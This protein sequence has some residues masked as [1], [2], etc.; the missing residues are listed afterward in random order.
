LTITLDM[1]FDEFKAN[2]KQAARDACQP[3]NFCAWDDSTE[4]CGCSVELQTSDPVL[5][6]ECLRAS[7]QSDSVCTWAG[8]D[9]D[10][11]AGG[12]YGIRFTMP[13]E[14]GELPDNKGGILQPD[15][16]RPDPRCF[17]ESSEWDVAWQEASEDL[18]GPECF[19]P[20]VQDPPDFCDSR[21]R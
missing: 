4:R 17:R 15:G 12:C 2:Y 19:Q 5:Y 1:G 6:Q 11:P 3:T 10:C 14:F 9:V 20:P 18:A 16:H 13:G 7:G 21:T 8:R